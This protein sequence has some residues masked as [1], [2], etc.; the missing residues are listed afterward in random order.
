MIRCAQLANNWATEDRTVSQMLKLGF[1]IPFY[2]EDHFKT[3]FS[4]PG[5]QVIPP[6]SEI[7]NHIRYWPHGSLGKVNTDTEQI[8]DIKLMTDYILSLSSIYP[9][10]TLLQA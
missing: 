5:N 3:D 9:Q 8:P 1:Y 6:I 10:D 2:S 7:K 4:G